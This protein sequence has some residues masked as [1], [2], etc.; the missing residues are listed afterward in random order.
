MNLEPMRTYVIRRVSLA[1]G[2]EREIA[3]MLTPS[4]YEEIQPF[5]IG[6]QREAGS[7]HIQGVLPEHSAEQREFVLTGM[8]PEEWNQP[9]GE[10]E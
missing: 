10:P 1:S 3:L 6:K 7:R 4:Q 5:L 9:F 8:T 2:T